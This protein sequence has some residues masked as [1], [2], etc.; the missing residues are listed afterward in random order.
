M[1]GSLRLRKYDGRQLRP[2]RDVEIA[3]IAGRAGRHM[4]DGTFGTTIDVGGLDEETVEAIENHRFDPLRD[5][6]W[7]NAE[8]DFRSIPALIASLNSRRPMP[9]C[10]GYASRT[11]RSPCRPW[12][13]CRSSCPA[14]TRPKE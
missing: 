10:K 12:R 11:T 13:K 1:S 9:R 2:L 5:L 4:N 3:Q 6:Q 8:L 14:C 7:R